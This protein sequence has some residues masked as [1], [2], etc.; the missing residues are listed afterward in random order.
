M[1]TR[2][3][4]V[5]FLDSYLLSAT[6]PDS[7]LNGL[8]VQGRPSV[9]KIVFGV[10]ANMELFKK[11][12]AAKADMIVVHHGLLWGKEQA[13]TGIFGRRVGFLLEN[14]ISLVGYH[15]PLDKHPVCGH[16]AQL[17]HVL[18]VQHLRPFATY[19]RQEIGF[20]GTIKPSDLPTLK[21][22]LE[23]ACGAKAF[24]LPYGPNRISKVGIVS[25]GGW[26]M[27]T[28]ALQAKL[29]LFVTGSVDEP[30]QEL[31][32]EGNINCIALGHYNSEKTGVLALMQLVAQQF[33]IET[34]FIDIQNPI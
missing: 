23:K 14:K 28:D 24:V 11:A 6:V 22:K 7:S 15:L 2:E 21:R 20:C 17:A 10:S 33:S 34:E 12:K 9:R 19:H 18:G 3:D 8:Q 26:S 1:T 27:I 31:C 32:R 30:L 25:G 5:N 13:L 16:N 4:I 29:D